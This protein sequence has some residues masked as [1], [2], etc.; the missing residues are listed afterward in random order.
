VY[1]EIT[2]KQSRSSEQFTH[3]VLKV[4]YI[5]LSLKIVISKTEAGESG[6]RIKA[7]IKK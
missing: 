5:A 3:N 2:C 7:D 4:L 1:L 6:L